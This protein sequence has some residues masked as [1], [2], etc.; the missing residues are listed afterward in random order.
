MRRF[1][2]PKIAFLKSRSVYSP[3]LGKAVSGAGLCSPVLRPLPSVSLIFRFLLC[4]LPCPSWARSWQQLKSLGH[5]SRRQSDS[6]SSHACAAPPPCPRSWVPWISFASVSSGSI[7][8]IRAKIYMRSLAKE[9]LLKQPF[10]SLLLGSHLLTLSSCL[11][12]ASA[13]LVIP[14]L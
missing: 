13:L 14:A 1:T 8:A 4:L 12:H 3:L 9:A 6:A 5:C 10:W 11:S 7:S 2:I